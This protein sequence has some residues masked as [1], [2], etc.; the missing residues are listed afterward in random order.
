M[1]ILIK[2]WRALYCF[3]AGCF[4]TGKSTGT[5]ERARPKTAFT[6]TYE[7]WNKLVTEKRD[8]EKQLEA[9]AEALRRIE[10]LTHGG[11]ILS[12]EYTKIVHELA[13]DGYGAAKK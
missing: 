8:I 7:D 13:Q 9:A 12:A 11:V 3:V 5:P 4:S 6:V 1:K 10:C 2:T